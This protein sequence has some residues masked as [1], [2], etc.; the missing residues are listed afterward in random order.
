MKWVHGF[1][2]FNFL[3]P[4]LFS[5]LHVSALSSCVGNQCVSLSG[6][7]WYASCIATIYRLLPLGLVRIDDWIF[8]IITL[9][10]V[11]FG[12]NPQYEPCIPNNP[13]YHPDQQFPLTQTVT[14]LSVNWLKPTDSVILN[15]LL[16]HDGY[17]LISWWGQCH[18]CW[19]TP[20][21]EHYR[22]WQM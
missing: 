16:A 11:S 6:R 13:R 17:R 3:S 2:V 18:C 19:E 22:P 14:P 12:P 8:T 5:F 20:G 4:I 10:S 7:S 21:L 1:I 9:C 15:V